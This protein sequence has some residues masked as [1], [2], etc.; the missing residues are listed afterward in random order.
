M[1][2]YSTFHAVVKTNVA[3]QACASKLDQIGHVYQIINEK[4]K[5]KFD[6]VFVYAVFW[7][8]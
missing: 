6:I 8:Y 2:Y 1:F 5:C 4:Q 3:N 7:L